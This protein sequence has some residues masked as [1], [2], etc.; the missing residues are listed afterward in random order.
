MSSYS[1][2][3][4]LIPTEN[5]YI[6]NAEYSN[7][8]S[9][10]EG[11]QASSSLL[12]DTACTSGSCV[13]T[14]SRLL[15]RADQSIT[16][17]DDFYQYACGNWINQSVNILYASWNS[18]YETQMK[19]HDKIVNVISQVL[20]DSF[21]TEMN[22]G[23]KAAALLYKQC[24]DLDTLEQVGLNTWKRYVELLGGWMPEL[25]EGG[26][27]DEP[28]EFE[29]EDMILT[30]FNY[31]VFP[32][33]WAG[34]EVSYFNS[35]KHSI[36]IYEQLPILLAAD[37]YT[38]DKEVTPEMIFS[39][40]DGPPVTLALQ[41]VGEELA[42]LLDFD[43]KDENVRMMIANMIHLEYQ[44]TSSGSTF[45]KEKK[46]R[47]EVVTLGQLQQIAPAINWRY[48]FSRLLGMELDYGEEIAIKTGAEW[49]VTLSRII[50]DLKK[51]RQGVAIIKNYI[52]WKTILFHLAYASPKC[53]N[54]LLWITVSLYGGARSQRKEFCVL[55]LSGIFPLSFPSILRKIDGMEKSDENKR[56][57]QNMTEHI[58]DEYRKII[59][60]T[61]VF[62]NEQ[63]RQ[64]VLDKISN[65]TK[66]ISFPDKMTSD[67]EMNKEANRVSDEFFWS[68][69]IGAS[70][71]YREKLK[72]LRK[73][74]DPKD[75]IDTRPALSIPA[76]NYERNLIQIPFDSLRLPYADK[77]QMDFANYAGIG[78]IIGH[79]M[80]HAF[81][82]QGKLHG[83]TGSLGHWWDVESRRKFTQKE[84]CFVRQYTQ[85]HASQDNAA[86]R[87]GLYE[88]IAD[89]VGLKVAYEAWKIHGKDQS[90]QLAGWNNFTQDQLFF[91][92]Y[93]QGWCALKSKQPREVHMEERYRMIGSLQ[94]SAE[95]ARAWQCPTGSYMNPKDKCT[96]W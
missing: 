39:K 66:H 84:H 36:T 14:A 34:V 30:A 68:M 48:F 76:H 86:A 9:L 75:W 35:S 47:Y 1:S 93:A 37:K 45:Y 88:N 23:E 79:E 81:D 77:S 56:M 22:A 43:R 49:I 94:N 44:I 11:K 73:A 32:L 70:S 91:L 50:A 2:L 19:A 59:E 25:A 24:T 82:A 54:G 57:V 26:Y 12:R 27:M 72:R 60:K 3:N 29:I 51:T 21:P 96:L 87:A 65:L 46:E 92:A 89:F 6:L 40:S 33:F 13:M 80:T 17:C 74:V 71:V 53:Q 42:E 28:S 61:D 5:T 83:P 62:V 63:T 58:S 55:R 90:A 69:A 4:N 18:L 7:G 10:E 8:V 85:L 64:N 31:T 52:K 41:E 16:P 95:F 20:D 15:S 38:F 78:S 67:Y